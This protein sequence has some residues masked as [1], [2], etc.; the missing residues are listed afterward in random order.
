MAYLVSK[1]A[2]ENGWQWRNA[3]SIF[4]LAWRLIMAK[5]RG[6]E[7]LLSTAAMAGMLAIARHESA[8]CR[9]WR[10]QYRKLQSIP[11]SWR[12]SKA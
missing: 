3:E 2:E 5:W 10:H 12:R 8:Q 9:K 1:A 4:G 6:G 11:A 7:S